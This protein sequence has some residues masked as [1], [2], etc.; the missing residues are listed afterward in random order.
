MSIILIW[1]DVVV[2]SGAQ[3]RDL[4]FYALEIES[5]F[6]QHPVRSVSDGSGS[7]NLRFFVD[8][9]AQRSGF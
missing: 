8:G 7:S 1:K 6:Y 9:Q 5:L 3:S 4:A 2:R